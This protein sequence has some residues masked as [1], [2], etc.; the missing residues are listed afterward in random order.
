M[1]KSVLSDYVENIPYNLEAE[2]S[3][4]GALL[5]DPSCMSK[6]LEYIKPDCFF[7]PQHNQIFDI[8]LEMFYTS[9]AID[10]V[11]VLA[12]VS[13][14]NI[15]ET[16]NEA[17]LYLAKLMEM[18]PSIV[19]IESY[20]EIVREYHYIRRLISASQEILSSCSQSTNSKFLL[21]KA[22]QLIMEIRH[23]R[24]ISGLEKLD[25]IILSIY[26]NLQKISE[27]EGLAHLGLSSGFDGLDAIL[28]GLNKSDLILLAARPAMGKTS[29]ALNIAT[30]CAKKSKK[31]V[32][33]FS[34]EMSKE[35]L[36]SRILSSEARIN[37]SKL[38]TG[39]LSGN[40]WE[41]LTIASNQ[42]YGTEIYIDDTPGINVAEMKGKLRRV[43]NLGLVVID[44]LQLM[45]SSKRTENRV[46]EISEITRNLKVLAKEFDVPVICL[47]QLSRAPDARADHRPIL[48]DLRESGSIEQD[49]DI[50]MFLYREHYYDQENGEENV[51]DCIISKNRHGETASI[52]LSWEGEFTK[53]GNLEK[54]YDY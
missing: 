36:A 18:V 15:F 10:F 49:A 48:S 29:F 7:H 14:D 5:L 9:N 19:N 17:K 23:G 44:Y 31:A 13:S 34:L 25:K 22:E 39:D 11:T 3:V 43:D 1:D 53:F 33:I 42:L 54:R 32:A 46:Q 38:K 28:T 30:N 2:Q 27:Q 12:E 16:K 26:D 51:A 20:C 4:L 6:V 52:S 8:I 24:D 37:S 45:T 50:V 35:Q 41:S 47:S 40:D 21:D